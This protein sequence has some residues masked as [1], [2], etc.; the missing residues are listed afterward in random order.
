MA[1]VIGLDGKALVEQLREAREAF[2]E[3]ITAFTYLSIHASAA[4][5]AGNTFR[6]GNL[7]A[8]CGPAV[9]ELAVHAANAVVDTPDLA[10]GV[11]SR[12]NAHYLQAA[13]EKSLE[14]RHVVVPTLADPSVI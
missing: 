5:V 10:K 7:L 2:P 1:A 3:L 14:D 4:V 12:I 8:D 11:M 6:R 9:A 13:M